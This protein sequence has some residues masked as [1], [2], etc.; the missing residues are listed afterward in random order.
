MQLRM[1]DTQK[2]EAI[3]LEINNRLQKLKEYSEDKYAEFMARS[4]GR[5][6]GVGE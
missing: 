5:E 2:K 6:V 3:V 1:K 4:R